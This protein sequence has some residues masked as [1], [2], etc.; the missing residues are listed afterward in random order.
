MKIVYTVL[1]N[2]CKNFYEYFLPLAENCLLYYQVGS[3]FS[4]ALLTYMYNHTYSI[5]FY[6]QTDLLSSTTACSIHFSFTNELMITIGGKSGHFTPFMEK[7]YHLAFQY[8][9]KKSMFFGS[10]LSV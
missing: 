8:S 7:K 10:S 4:S 1:F 5:H 6:P 3:F 2:V 9:T